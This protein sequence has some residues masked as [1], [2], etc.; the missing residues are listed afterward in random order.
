MKPGIR[1]SQVLGDIRSAAESD[2]NAALI[3]REVMPALSVLVFNLGEALTQPG[4]S[5]VCSFNPAIPSW[6]SIWKP[7]VPNSWSQLLSVCARTRQNR[8]KVVSV[9]GNVRFPEIMY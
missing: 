8:Q 4:G 6:C 7:I 2:L 9:V 5:S 3:Q 1:V